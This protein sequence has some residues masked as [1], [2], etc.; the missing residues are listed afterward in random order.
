MAKSIGKIYVFI[1]TNILLE[2]K[3][4]YQIDWNSILNYKQVTLVLTRVVLKELEKFK[5]DQKSER[6]Q[7]RSRLMMKQIDQLIFSVDPNEEAPIPSR[8]NVS[9][10]VLTHSPQLN[11]Y[12]DLEESIADDQLIASI[13]NFMKVNSSIS[14]EDIILIGDDAGCLNKARAHGIKVRRLDDA[15]RLPDEPSA[16]QKEAARLRRQVE[17]LQNRQPKPRLTIK[18]PDGFVQELDVQLTILS[19]PDEAHIEELNVREEQATHWEAPKPPDEPESIADEPSHIK[20]ARVT[21]A[22]LAAMSSR[23]NISQKEI[24]R[25]RQD[26]SDYLQSYRQF[27]DLY[28]SFQERRFRTIGISFSVV[29]D[30]NTPATG[31]VIQL[32]IPDELEVITEEDLPQAPKRPR[33]PVFPR[34]EMQLLSDTINSTTLLPSIFL[35]PSFQGN[36]L[37]DPD[38]EGPEITP[39]NS[40]LVRWRKSKVMHHIPLDLDEIFIRFPPSINTREYHLKYEIIAD[41][42]PDPLTGI[43]KITVNG[44]EKRFTY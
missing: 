33:R 6:R 11:L 19:N 35:P 10:L 25:Y 13:L 1:D 44:I 4:F 39:Y 43:L 20:A 24:E 7:S 42:T 26:R 18:T 28:Y 12:P 36:D 8:Q 38:S 16:S 31:I 41:N 27:L 40:T 21:M 9:L 37:V 32:V 14:S 17:E 29:N 22:Q 3:D 2:F 30:G 5:Y 23:G 15:Y 34:T